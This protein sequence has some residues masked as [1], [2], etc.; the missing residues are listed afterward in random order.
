MNPNAILSFLL[1][2]G[3]SALAACAKLSHSSAYSAIA[4]PIRCDILIVGGGTGG[5]A[6]ALAAASEGPH[7]CLL[8]ETDWL[9]GQF[10]SQGLTM[11]D[12]NRFIEHFG[13]THR[14]SAFRQ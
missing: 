13:G 9:G 4:P 6:A 3:F 5:T 8:A 11:P 10:T 7:L 2:C 1:V 14:Y 12:E